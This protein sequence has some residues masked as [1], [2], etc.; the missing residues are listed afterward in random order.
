MGVKIGEIVSNMAQNARPY[1]FKG[2]LGAAAIAEGMF[3][4]S[5]AQQANTLNQRPAHTDSVGPIGPDLLPVAAGGLVQPFKGF[6]LQPKAAQAAELGQVDTWPLTQEA[7]AIK[8]GVDIGFVEKDP[9]SPDDRPSWHVVFKDANGNNS[10]GD[11]IAPEGSYFSAWHP[12]SGWTLFGSDG[13]MLSQVADVT[14]RP[15]E[16]FVY[17]PDKSLA[18]KAAIWDMVGQHVQAHPDVPFGI[19]KNGAWIGIQTLDQFPATTKEVGKQ[20]GQWP[21][22][23]AQAAATFGV[24]ERFLTQEVPANRPSWHVDFGGGIGTVLAPNLAYASAWQPDS[25]TTLFSAQAEKQVRFERVAD[26]TLR[27]FKNFNCED[28]SEDAKAAIWD[29]VKDHVKDHPDVPFAVLMGNSWQKFR[30]FY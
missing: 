4:P 24:E 19:L 12:N 17:C 29:M 13:A 22:N 26:V 30:R 5:V 3:G 16:D 1:A 7:A 10:V 11:V 20:T 8:F 15:L 27:P 21:L 9:G 14:L 23:K 25:G 28:F 2:A 18:K 6:E